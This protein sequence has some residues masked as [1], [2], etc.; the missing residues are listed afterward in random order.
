MYRGK[1]LPLS[2]LLNEN[3]FC[4]R[5]G[6]VGSFLAV[7]VGN[8]E[9]FSFRLF[10]I[11]GFLLL[12]RQRHSA[13]AKHRARGENSKSVFGILFRFGIFPRSF[14]FFLNEDFFFAGFVL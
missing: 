9:D 2:P 13:E 5:S 6:L 11:L 14:F 1:V 7:S 8:F 12:R 10:F 4:G 3:R